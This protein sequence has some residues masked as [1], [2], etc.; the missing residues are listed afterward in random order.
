MKGLD[1]RPWVASRDTAVCLLLYGCGLRVGEALSLKRREAPQ[2][3]QE[4]LLITGKG[5]ADGGGE[6]GVLR[7]EL[8]RWLNQPRNRERVVALTPAQ[9]RDGGDGAFY[10]RLKRLRERR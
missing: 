5:K 7:R 9:P 8:P 3:G 6:R 4:S 10:L 1:P 2:A